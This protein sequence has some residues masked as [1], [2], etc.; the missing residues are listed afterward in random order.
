MTSEFPFLQSERIDSICLCLLWASLAV[1]WLVRGP[2]FIAGD[3][4]GMLV[5]GLPAAGSHF[6]DAASGQSGGKTA[7]ACTA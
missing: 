6:S 7:G 2:R 1:F 5:E 3:S 4:A